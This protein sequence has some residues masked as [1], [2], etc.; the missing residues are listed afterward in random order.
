MWSTLPPFFFLT[1]L[2]TKKIYTLGLSPSR[3]TCAQDFYVLKKSIDLSRVW[4]REPWIS[5]ILFP[6][7]KS[8]YLYTFKYHVSCTNGKIL[9]KIIY[10]YYLFFQRR[11]VQ[12]CV[13]FPVGFSSLMRHFQQVLWALKFLLSCGLSSW[14]FE[15]KS[16][17]ILIFGFQNFF[18]C[19]V[20]GKKTQHW[21]GRWTV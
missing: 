18:C 13:F 16:L 10:F 1:S 9:V 21:M 3:R 4:T 11:P 20:L 17:I 5:K 8:F 14:Q 19:L 15:F 2:D 12:C 7:L 6:I